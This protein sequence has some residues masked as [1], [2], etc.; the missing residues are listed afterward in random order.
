[1]KV[2][3]RI[4]IVAVVVGSAESGAQ[5]NRVTLS[6]GEVTL[7]RVDAA[8]LAERIP[9][10]PPAVRGRVT[11]SGDS[12]QR[13]AMEDFDWRGRVMSVEFDIEDARLFWDVKIIPDSTRQTIVRYRVDAGTGGILNI[14]EFTGIR[15]LPRS[16]T[17]ESPSWEF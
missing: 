15:G 13:V 2:C 11:V 9:G 14:R 17:A 3:M 6:G 16:L 5:A 10:V 8:R 1:M 7:S 4:A 12:A